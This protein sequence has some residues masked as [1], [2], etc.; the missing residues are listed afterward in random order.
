M[1]QLGVLWAEQRAAPHAL[2]IM[3]SRVWRSGSGDHR[4]ESHFRN[5]LSA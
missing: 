4:S 3:L 2:A 1:R 5:G